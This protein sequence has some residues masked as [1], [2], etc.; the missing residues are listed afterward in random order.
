[1]STQEKS[2][3]PSVEKLIF[4]KPTYLPAFWYCVAKNPCLLP[5]RDP[6]RRGELRSPAPVAPITGPGDHR[7][8]L[9][10]VPPTTPRDKP[11]FAQIN[12]HA[13]KQKN[14]RTFDSSRKAKAVL[15]FRGTTFVAA[16]SA[17]PLYTQRG[18]DIPIALPCNGGDPAKPIWTKSV[19][20]AAPRGVAPSRPTALSARGRTGSSGSRDC[21]GFFVPARSRSR[22]R[23]GGYVKRRTTPQGRKRQREIDCRLVRGL[24]KAALY[25]WCVAKR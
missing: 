23:S 12:A 11:G 20:P 5:R 17:R 24:P 18:M 25:K 22:R 13:N 4:I 9:R 8:P 19:Q 1:M 2:G 14:L 15:A 6:N 16:Q 3:Q 7:S 10:I 21:G